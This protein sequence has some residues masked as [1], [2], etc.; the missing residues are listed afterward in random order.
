MARFGA[1]RETG[2]TLGLGNTGLG[3][4][5]LLVALPPRL[6]RDAT[7]VAVEDLELGRLDLL[8]GRSNP[9]C[10]NLSNPKAFCAAAL[11]DGRSPIPPK[12]SLET[13]P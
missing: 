7:D 11:L 8:D 13:G 4:G 9:S 3:I 1:K 2:A 6:D 5:K 10:S 12:D